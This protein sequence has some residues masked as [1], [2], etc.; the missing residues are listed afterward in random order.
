MTLT[1]KKETSDGDLITLEE[2]SNMLTLTADIDSEASYY[3]EISDLSGATVS[4]NY[5]YLTTT[6]LRS[7]VDDRIELL[8][9][10]W[11]ISL[12]SI[13]DIEQAIEETKP[14][15]E[16]IVQTPPSAKPVRNELERH[17]AYLDTTVTEHHRSREVV[18]P[19]L[20]YFTEEPVEDLLQML[21]HVVLTEI[22]DNCK[23]ITK[24]YIVTV[25]FPEVI[26]KLIMN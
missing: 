9:K 8:L 7:S 15:M 10:S 21:S 3:C 24:D 20:Y 4:S 19:G 2:T 5:C 26:T 14:F 18:T 6:L 23:I 16:S 12:V 11:Q 1:W 13:Q 25:L 22:V 17:V